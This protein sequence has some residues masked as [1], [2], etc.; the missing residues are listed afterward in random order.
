MGAVGELE[1]QPGGSHDVAKEGPAPGGAAR[2][3]ELDARAALALEEAAAH[4]EAAIGERRQGVDRI[5]CRDQQAI[6]DREVRAAHAG[7]VVGGLGER[8]ERHGGAPGLGL[9]DTAVEVAHERLIADFK[10]FL[11]GRRW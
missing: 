7:D 4:R 1:E 3:R 6:P 11:G 2:H 5:A 8:G 9:E 10:R